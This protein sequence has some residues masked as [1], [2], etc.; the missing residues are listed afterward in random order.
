M[1]KKIACHSKATS[2]FCANTGVA[3]AYVYESLGFIKIFRFVFCLFSC[4]QH[5]RI[6]AKALGG[7]LKKAFQKSI[8]VPPLQK[9]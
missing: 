2:V 6:T 9:K 4:H 1:K 7:G 3:R 8:K 5:G